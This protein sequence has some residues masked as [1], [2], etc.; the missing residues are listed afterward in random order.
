MVSDLTPNAPIIAQFQS[1]PGWRSSCSSS[2]HLQCL[3]MPFPAKQMDK[4]HT[5]HAVNPAETIQS[6]RSSPSPQRCGSW[7]ALVRPVSLGWVGRVSSGWAPGWGWCSPRARRWGWWSSWQC[8]QRPVK[9]KKKKESILKNL[10]CEQERGEEG[11]TSPPWSR[12]RAW[13]GRP[14]PGRGWTRTS[15]RPQSASRRGRGGSSWS[16]CRTWRH[17]EAT[18]SDL[19]SGLFQ[20]IYTLLLV[21]NF[22]ETFGAS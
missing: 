5:H 18:S 22:M 20:S 13:S 1:E 2:K 6:V 3:E 9:K 4:S 19:A 15:S 21:L 16:G 12:C 10:L 11:Q 7:P 14:S 17:Q 8:T